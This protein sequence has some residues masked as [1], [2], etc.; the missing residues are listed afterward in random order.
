[1]KIYY[2][3]RTGKS[4]R[5]AKE[6]AE[7]NG[8]IA[9]KIDDGKNWRGIFKF[10]VA[11]FMATKSKTLPIKYLKPET[12]EDIVLVFPVWAS[13]FPPAI[14]TFINDIGRDKII[15]LPVS[16][17]SMLKDRVGFIKIIDLVGDDAK[18]P[19]SL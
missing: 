17:G 9:N 1:M 8:S 2:F 10:I 5:I 15:L 7:Q 14:R 19:K 3:T 6:L 11:G 4:E 13:F 12:N 18:A 16:A